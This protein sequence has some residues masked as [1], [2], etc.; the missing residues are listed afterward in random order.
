VVLTAVPP[1]RTVRVCP[2]E[3]VRPLLVC[4]EETVMETTLSIT[5]TPPLPSDVRTK[6][7]PERF[8]DGSRC[9]T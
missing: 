6:C 2:L 3:T 9:N 4:P 5:S 7:A 8:C 1:D